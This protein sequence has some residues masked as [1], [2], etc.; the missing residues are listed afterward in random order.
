ME[1]LNK[2]SPPVKL[3]DQ[4]RQQLAEL[5]SLY[6]AKLAEREIGLRGEMERAAASGDVES[7]E[8]LRGQLAE[9]RRGLQAELETKK[10][11]VRQG[12]SV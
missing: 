3:T 12:M 7:M 9:E 8:R 10:E 2:V 11:R 4:Q 5:D 6:A 1:R